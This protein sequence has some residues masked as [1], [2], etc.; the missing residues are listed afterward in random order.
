MK[1][2]LHAIISVFIGA[3]SLGFSRDEQTTAP[4]KQT[5]RI[6]SAR[7]LGEIP[8]GTPPPPEPPKPAFIIPAKDILKTTTHQQGG[9]TITVR[10]ITPIALPEPSKAVAPPDTSQPAI[11]ARTAEITAKY[12]DQELL[13]IGATVLHAQD[14]TIRS[15]VQISPMGG[16]ESVRFWSSADFALLSGFSSFI[17]SDGDAH[18]LM[19]SWSAEKIDSIAGFIEKQGSEYGIAK[20]PEL[21]AGKAAFAIIS[22]K[23]TETTLASIQS[24]HDLYNNE[25]D[26]LQKAYEGRERA[27]LQH[28]AELI[29]NPPKPKEIVLNYWRTEKPAAKK[30]SAQ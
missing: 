27:R 3:A 20:A 23:P 10:K 11:Q 6:T 4:D 1:N 24:L 9:R 28:E 19:M 13:F 30:G 21:P 22:E 8:N 5:H 7:I 14:S 18:S 16:G 12:P 25:H 29:A 15:L 2:Y 17:G 26:R